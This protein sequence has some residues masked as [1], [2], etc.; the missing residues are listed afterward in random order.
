M[1]LSSAGSLLPSYG[2][3]PVDHLALY[4]SAQFFEKQ[5]VKHSASIQKKALGR[6]RPDG[7]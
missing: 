7:L 6:S 5:S 2:S 4:G 1:A 3:Q